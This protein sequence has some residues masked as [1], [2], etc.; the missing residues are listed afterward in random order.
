MSEELKQRVEE[1]EKELSEVST[2]LQRD[3]QDR[4]QLD[5]RISTIV[6]DRTEVI[7]MMREEEPVHRLTAKI[8]KLQRDLDRALFRFNEDSGMEHV[9]AEMEAAKDAFHDIHLLAL[10][11]KTWLEKSYDDVHQEV[12]KLNPPSL[13]QK[14]LR[15]R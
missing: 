10:N 14:I 3:R 4:D 5:D 9:K 15:R 7:Q 13:W 11:A 12:Q 2:A 6:G 8:E 1:L